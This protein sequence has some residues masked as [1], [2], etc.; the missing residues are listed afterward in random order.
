MT[1]ASNST[2]QAITTFRTEGDFANPSDKGNYDRI[3]DCVQ[4]TLLSGQTTEVTLK[5]DMPYTKPSQDSR[6][7][8]ST[9]DRLVTNLNSAGFQVGTEF[10]LYARLMGH[11]ATISLPKEPKDESGYVSDGW[12]VNFKASKIRSE[13]Q[14]SFNNAKLVATQEIESAVGAN[15]EY[16]EH[17]FFVGNLGCP[18]FLELKLIE[19]LKK[20]LMDQGVPSGSITTHPRAITIK[21]F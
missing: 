11:Q 21:K 15:P 19:E 9:L 3:K 4:K 20:N 10:G 2:S 13:H 1:P 12:D 18:P 17:V 8:P 5:K 6:L 7:S 16:K 14:D